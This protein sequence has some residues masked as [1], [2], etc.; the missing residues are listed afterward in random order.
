MFLLL[1]LSQDPGSGGPLKVAP[2]QICPSESGP[3]RSG[4]DSCLMSPYDALPAL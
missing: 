1:L 2:L 3:S 4:D